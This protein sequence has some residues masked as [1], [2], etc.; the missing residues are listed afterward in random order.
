MVADKRDTR[1]EPFQ[2]DLVGQAVRLRGLPQ[3][4]PHGPAVHQ[5]QTMA[6]VV[7]A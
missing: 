5:K 4:S 7:H 3:A 6:V 1:G 2:A